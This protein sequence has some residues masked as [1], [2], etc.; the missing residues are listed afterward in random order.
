[1]H[2][3]ARVCNYEYISR[4]IKCVWTTSASE[5][6][7]PRP[8]PSPLRRRQ[9]EEGMGKGGKGKGGKAPPAPKPDDDD[10]LL[11]AAIA[12]ANTLRA[13]AEANKT[14]A[15]TP[16]FPQKGARGKGGGK[17]SGAASGRTKA[18]A[19]AAAAAAAAAG[20]GR[21]FSMQETLAKLDTVMAFTIAQLKEDGFRDVVPSPNG[22]VTF[23]L[24]A[25]DAKKDMVQ[26]MAANPSGPKLVLDY[27]PLGR[28][29][30]LS[31]GLMGLK[32]PVPTKIQF[33]RA[34][35][36]K[37]NDAGIPEELRTGMAG[38][39]PFPLFY[40]D[41]LG[42]ETFTPVFFT[43]EDLGSFWV[44]CGGAMDQVPEPTISDL[45]I[46][47]ARTLQEPG[48]W[49]ALH[50]VPPSGSEALTKD[51]AARANKDAALRQGFM[52]GA[53][54]LKKV[55]HEVAVADGDEPPALA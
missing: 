30:A 28:A 15:P 1:M 33:S 43:K 2:A 8:V 27:T 50:F 4:S 42:G 13:Q 55:A 7:S 10:A 29:F 37:V 20:Q 32:T 12:E 44:S 18:D 41:K 52:S 49:E 34:V 48:N 38:V 40:S 51:L 47:V 45:R 35:I 54:K 14:A 25:V 39:G 16:Y 5:N 53:Q 23:Y 3:C 31:Q 36:E 11:E 19:A 46:I 9:G 17:G 6:A 22:E 26:L 21:V 24:D